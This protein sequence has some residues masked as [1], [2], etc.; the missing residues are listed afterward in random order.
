MKKILVLSDSHGNVNNMVTAVSRLQPDIIIHLG[1]CWADAEQLHRKFPMTIM[2]QVPGN[3][4]CRQD[5]PERILLI[6]GKKILICHGHTFNVKAGYLNLEYAAE[7]RKV[8]AALFGHTHRVFY[9][10]HNRIAYMNPGSIG[11]RGDVDVDRAQ[12]GVE[13]AGEVEEEALGCRVDRQARLRNERGDAGD[14]DDAGAAVHVGEAPVDELDGR[15]HEERHHLARALLLLQ[16][17]IAEGAEARVVD[18]QRDAEVVFL[19]E[20]VP[21]D[22]EGVLLG[23]VEAERAD[24]GG[25]GALQGLEALGAA[26]DDPDLVEFA[27]LALVEAAGELSSQARRGAG[28]DGDVLHGSSFCGRG[29]ALETVCSQKKPPSNEGRRPAG[30]RIYIATC[31]DCC[32]CPHV[33]A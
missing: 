10:K 15:P 26:R 12:L 27:H 6:E 28:D 1:D 8:D 19:R 18:E 24:G 17:E 14:V 20:R 32:K 11:H 16:G 7:E 25:A 3:C 2:E 29:C 13:G 23:E 31:G 30:V 33:L 5:I 9:D 22:V 21:D 4:D